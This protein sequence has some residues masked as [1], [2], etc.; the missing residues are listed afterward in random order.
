MNK[1]SLLIKMLIYGLLGFGIAYAY[2]LM[3][4]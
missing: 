2:H 1:K 3:H 4:N